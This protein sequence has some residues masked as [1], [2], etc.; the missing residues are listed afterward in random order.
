MNKL[1]YTQSTNLA[2]YLVMN[3]F[4]IV[5]VYKENGKVTMYFDKTDALH[6]CVRK[7]NTEIELKQFISAFKKVKETIRF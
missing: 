1:Y 2:A 5:T 6:D 7:Y 3:G 4:Q